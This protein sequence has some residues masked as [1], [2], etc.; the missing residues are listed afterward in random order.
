MKKKIEIRT[1]EKKLKDLC[2]IRRKFLE[3]QK[4]YQDRWLELDDI[5]CALECK[6]NLEIEGGKK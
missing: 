2:C 5:I 1:R 3:K 4:Y 6:I